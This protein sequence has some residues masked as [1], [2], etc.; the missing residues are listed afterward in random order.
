M[1]VWPSRTYDIRAATETVVVWKTTEDKT[2]TWHKE[3]VE[4]YCNITLADDRNDR[5]V[6]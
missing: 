1:M 4:T 2:K 6:V 3:E 5:W